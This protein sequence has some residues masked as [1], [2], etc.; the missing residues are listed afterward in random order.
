MS[1]V[2]S[3]DGRT[4]ATGGFDKTIR[5]W[6]VHKGIHLQTHNGHTDLVYALD[7]N[8]DGSTLAS[9]SRDGTVLLWDMTLTDPMDDTPSTPASS[10]ATVSISTTPVQAPVIGKLLTFPLNITDGENVAGYQATVQFDTTVLQYVSSEKRRLSP[11]RCIFCTT[12]C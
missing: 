3:P 2:F 5:I 10:D 1:V 7:F 4:L 6:D 12:C 8:A 11:P 9:G